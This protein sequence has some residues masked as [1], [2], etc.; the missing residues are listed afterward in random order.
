MT[1]DHRVVVS[2]GNLAVIGALFTLA[3]GVAIVGGAI[4]YDVG[5]GSRGPEPGYFP[6]WVGLVIVGASFGTLVQALV[7]RKRHPEPALT[8]GQARRVL[9]FVLPM[10]GFLL[11]TWQLGLYAGMLL[12]L[13]GVMIWQGGYRP[14]TAVPIAVAATLTFYLMFDVWLKVPLKKGPLETLLGLH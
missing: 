6:F 5:W 13:A 11:A 10:V 3:F 9:A 1:E 4:E 2:R 12:Y 14:V 7:A 8:V